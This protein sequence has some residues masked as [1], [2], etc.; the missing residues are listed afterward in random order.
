[1][2]WISVEE[3]LPPVAGE[4]VLVCSVPGTE[5]AFVAFRLLGGEWHRYIGEGY[6]CSVHPKIEV[7]THW[8]PLPEPPK[9]KGPF[10]V[11]ESSSW[12]H[13]EGA[14]YGVRHK[15]FGWV[16][17]FRGHIAAQQVCDR[18]NKIWTSDKGSTDDQ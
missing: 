13:P 3:R 11:G 16:S 12:P 2:E 9:D 1:M 17:D 10:I 6:L 18:L 4:R 5:N 8:M 15:T 14:L 7:P